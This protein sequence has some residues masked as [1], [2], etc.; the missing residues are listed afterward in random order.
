MPT[1]LRDAIIN[2]TRKYTKL[3]KIKL[4]NEITD[5]IKSIAKAQILIKI[6]RFCLVTN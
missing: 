1:A 2:T 5:T 4:F 6:E 3:G